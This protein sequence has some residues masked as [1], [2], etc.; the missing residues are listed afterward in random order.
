M[1]RYLNAFAYPATFM[2]IDRLPRLSEVA[3]SGLLAPYDSAKNRVAID[4][5]VRDIPLT[6]SH[7]TYDVLAQIEQSLPVLEPKQISMVW[8][9]KDWCFRP[10]CLDRFEAVFPRAKV[11]RLEDVGHYVMEEAPLEVL[12]E[13]KLLHRQSEA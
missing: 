1:I 12:H 8:G 9:M 3:K 2:A 13:L 10:E 7:P 4:G 11:N 5:F 6:K